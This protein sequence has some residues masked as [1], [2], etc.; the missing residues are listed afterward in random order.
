MSQAVIQLDTRPL[1]Y[2]LPVEV[3]FNLSVRYQEVRRARIC[4]SVPS[5]LPPCIILASSLS[6]K[7]CDHPVSRLDNTRRTSLTSEHITSLVAQLQIAL[8]PPV[9]QYQLQLYSKK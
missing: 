9:S 7:S 3:V 4:S 1:R 2:F 8:L 6:P 5:P